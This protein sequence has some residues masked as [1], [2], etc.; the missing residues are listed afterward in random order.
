MNTHKEYVE[1]LARGVSREIFT[2]IEGDNYAE[3]IVQLHIMTVES[4]LSRAFSIA[5]GSNLSS[6]MELKQVM[7]KINNNLNLGSENE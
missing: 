6:Q 7:E 2:K 4:L 1:S 5:I 3:E